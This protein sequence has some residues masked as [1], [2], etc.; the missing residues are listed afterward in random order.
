MNANQWY[1]VTVAVNSTS[2]SLI[3]IN[4]RFEN[5][6][7][8]TIQPNTGAP[9]TIGAS[10]NSVLSN[11]YFSGI[12]DEVMVWNRTLTAQEISD[13]YNMTLYGQ[14]DQS[15]A[16]HSIPYLNARYYN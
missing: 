4:G 15:G 10:S 12:I 13:I 3:Y 7:N 2:G 16:N 11:S 9:F 5:S 8:F 1:L 14:I 6:S